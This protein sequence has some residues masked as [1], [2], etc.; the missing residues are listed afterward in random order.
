MSKKEN[1]NV[2]VGVRIRPRNDKEIQASMPVC[3]SSSE[4]ARDVQELNEDGDV[5]KHWS[6]DNVFGPENNNKFIFEA[7]GMKLVDAAMDGYNSVLFMYGQTS[8]GKNVILTR[9]DYGIG[10]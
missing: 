3:F 4:D 8:S 6:Y 9:S 7:M 5:V 2:S 10:L 1:N